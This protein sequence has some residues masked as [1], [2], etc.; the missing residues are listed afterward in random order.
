MLD[1]NIIHQEFISKNTLFFVGNGNR[2]FGLKV[3]S[4]FKN[5]QLSTCIVERFANGE[6]KIP[7]IQENIRKRDCI[8]IQ[9]VSATSQYNLNDLMME[10]FV[11]IDAVK[12]GSATSIRVILPI[13]PYQRQDRKDYS[14]AP[15]SSKMI[16]S[17]LETQGIDRVIT[18]DLHAGQI[19]GFFDKTM[20]DNIYTEPYFINYITN[21]ILSKINPEDLVI[22]SPDEGGVKTAT[23][24]AEKLKCAAAILYKERVSAGSVN[25]MILMGDVKDKVCFMMD[26]M[27]DTAGTA[28]KACEVL[29][30]NGAK[31]IYIGACHGVLSN[32]ALQRIN[33]SSF[34]KVIVTNTVDVLGR[35]EG[36]NTS[37]L[38]VIDVSKI[39]AAAIERSIVGQ[40][41][42]E[43]MVL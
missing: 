24:V 28:C 9:S 22:V 6:I 20:L 5:T 19:Q 29:K 38:E 18:F 10:L 41:L 21:K 8:V 37:K 43:I 36:Q 32:P 2:E 1:Y 15:I 3:A 25:R 26:D 34:E 17:F 11:L 31:E 42:S 4:Y 35:F 12:R 39:C 40:S 14:R 30:E 13:F 23:R 16:A 33:D 27:I 7:K